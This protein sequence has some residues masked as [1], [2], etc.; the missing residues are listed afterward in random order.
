MGGSSRGE[1]WTCWPARTCASPLTKL[2]VRFKFLS[3]GVPVV[4]DL[5][6][7]KKHVDFLCTIDN[8]FKV[9]TLKINRHTRRVL[10]LLAWRILVVVVLFGLTKFPFT[11]I[12]VSELWHLLSVSNFSLP[13]FHCSLRL[14][15]FCSRTP[16]R[17]LLSNL[18]LVHVV[19]EPQFHELIK[20]LIT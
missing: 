14:H 4:G 17:Q 13:Y 5:A 6:F 2:C 19:N 16:F 9:R 18:G 1:T 7:K 3:C 10:C 11:T 20:L 12:V 8:F 15:C